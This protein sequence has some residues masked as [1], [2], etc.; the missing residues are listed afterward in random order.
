MTSREELP[1]PREDFALTHFP[2]VADQ[3]RSRE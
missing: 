1:A 2:V 3:D